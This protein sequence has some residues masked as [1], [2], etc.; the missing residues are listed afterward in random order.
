MI[1]DRNEGQKME[2]SMQAIRRRR[3]LEVALS[4]IL[5]FAVA[6]T[7]A[8]DRTVRVG[9]LSSGSLELRG[10]LEQALL[11]GLRDQGYVEGRNL[12]IERR[13][14]TGMMQQQQIP[15]YARELAG[16]KLDAIV[17]TC[18]PSTRAAKDATGSTP[19]VMAAVSDPVGQR[20]IASLTRPGANV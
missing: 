12:V 18:T 8:A 10:G 20:L 11:Q 1:F 5:L 15:Q 2:V 4:T 14:S 7:Y 17:T 9:I 3:F 16:M 19:I 13:Y 6:T